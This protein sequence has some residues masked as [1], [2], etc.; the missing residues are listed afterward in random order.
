MNEKN[1]PIV[2]KVLDEMDLCNHKDILI[3]LLHDNYIINFPGYNDLDSFA[4]S[5]YIDMVRYTA[6]KSAIILGAYENNHLIGFL[7][8]YR[9][10]FLHEKRIHIDHIIVYSLVR[11]KGIGTKLIHQLEAIAEKEGI[12]C[13]DLITSFSNE[14]TIQFYK[15]KGFSLTRVQFEKKL[16]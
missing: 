3:E 5:N 2:I 11:N 9:R 15:S 16:G 7:W 1:D 6:D 8:G 4:N 13:I 14:N 12:Q 10:E